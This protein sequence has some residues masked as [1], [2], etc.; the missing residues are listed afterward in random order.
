MIYD[1]DPITIALE[2]EIGDPKLFTGRRV[3]LAYFLDQA[4]QMQAEAEA[5]TAEAKE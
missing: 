2:E 1:S 3:D 4:E 5:A